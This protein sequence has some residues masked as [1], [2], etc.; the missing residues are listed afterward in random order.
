[1]KKIEQKIKRQQQIEQGAYDGRF[2]SKVVPNKK[3][4]QNKNWARKKD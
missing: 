3:K 4:K 2:K 1:M